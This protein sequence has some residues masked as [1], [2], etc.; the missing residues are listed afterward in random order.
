MFVVKRA[1]RDA[2]GMV[3]A[4]SIVEPA[5]IRRFKHR[6]LEGH[7]VEVTEQNFDKYA[8]FFKKKHGVD[9]PP[10]KPAESTELSKPEST[11]LPDVKPAEDSAKPAEDSAKPA[12]DSG[13]VKPAA[14]K[15]TVAA[16]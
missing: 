5:G 6:K 2:A 9:L 8:E 16:K 11:E 13:K 3:P 4:G 12:E 10:I 14:V 15:V 1:F 7:I